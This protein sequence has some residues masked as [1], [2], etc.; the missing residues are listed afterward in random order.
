M[1]TKLQNF[2]RTHFQRSDNGLMQVILI[3]GVIFV[4]LLLTKIVLFLADYDTLYQVLQQSLRLPAP[5]QVFLHQPWSMLTYFWLQED[6]ISAALSLLLLYTFGQFIMHTLGSRSL[7]FLYML[8]GIAGGSTFLLLYN[9]APG[10]KGTHTSLIGMMGSFYAIMA[11]TATL[12]PHFAF[13]LLFFGSIPIKYI[14]GFLLLLSLF[15][16]SGPQPAHGIAN[17]GGALAGYIYIQYRKRKRTMRPWMGY[18]K[19]FSN[20]NSKFRVTYVHNSPIKQD[21]AMDHIDQEV[22]DAILDKIA[23]SGYQSLSAQEKHQL[24]QAGHQ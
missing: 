3:N 23:S 17:L 5:W 21:K 6:F 20:K 8:G 12:S 14:L 16:L 19:K 1:L 22:L 11:A 9:L 18:F 24:F 7:I 15:E 4:I 10:L 13:R 2:L